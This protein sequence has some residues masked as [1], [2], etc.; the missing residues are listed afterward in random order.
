MA[1]AHAVAGRKTATA[2]RIERV[3]KCSGM[4]SL[5]AVAFLSYGDQ[6]EKKKTAKIEQSEISQDN[7]QTL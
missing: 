1:R 2:K 5:F 6:D 3:P 4:E 7:C